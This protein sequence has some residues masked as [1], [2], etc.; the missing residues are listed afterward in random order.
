MSKEYQKTT[1]TAQS[2]D[3]G[4]QQMR[5]K[6]LEYEVAVEEK[7]RKLKEVKLRVEQSV[8]E[9]EEEKEEYSQFIL[10]ACH[11]IMEH[12]TLIQNRTHELL[13]QAEEI[14]GQTKQAEVP[15]SSTSIPEQAV[16][17][18]S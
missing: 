15:K 13:E 5:A 3:E 11:M 7:E 8:D 1:G 4:V 17:E 10:K 14:L 12:K 18:Q 9:R 6:V 16:E 2:L